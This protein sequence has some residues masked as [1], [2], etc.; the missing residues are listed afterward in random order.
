[1]NQTSG[2]Q[3]GLSNDDTGH[4]RNAAAD[5]KYSSKGEGVAETAK[6]KGT[7]STE[8]PGVSICPRFPK[9]ML[10]TYSPRTRRSRARTRW[11]RANKANL[12]LNFQRLFRLS[13]SGLIMTDICTVLPPTPPACT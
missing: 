1:M 6:L 2:K 9:F 11:T 5:P 10:T 13:L 4:T 7:V 8:R 3:Q 12:D